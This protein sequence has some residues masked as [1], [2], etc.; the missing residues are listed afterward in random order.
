M[1][2]QRKKV[3]SEDPARDAGTGFSLVVRSSKK[4]P[5]SAGISNRNAL[6]LV[7]E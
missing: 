7:G 2:I 1:N 3:D 6:C 5:I 4:K